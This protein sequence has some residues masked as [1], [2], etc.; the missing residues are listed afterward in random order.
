MGSASLARP[1]HALSV[2]SPTASLSSATGKSDHKRKR[3]DA[4]GAGSH[5]APSSTTV[6]SQPQQTGMGHHLL[7]QIHYAVEYLKE[8]DRA[9]SF[10]DIT[11]YL[12]LQNVS[13]QDRRAIQQTLQSHRSVD[14]DRHGLDGQGSFRFRPKHNVRSAEELRRYLQQRTTA[15]GIPVRELKDGW[16]G[17]IEAISMLENKGE[18]LV[19]RNK[20]DNQPKMVWLNDPSLSLAVDDEFQTMWHEVRLPAN[21]DELRGKLEQAGLKPTSAP[22]DGSMLKGQKREK[23][24]AVRRT[25]KLTNTHM[26]GILKDYSHKRKAG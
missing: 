10:T 16:S 5:G 9:L 24:R 18:V 3:G 25:G 17:A 2:P 7:T 8:K 22:K 6:Y 15:Q 13:E 4:F 21:P 23:K 14:Y 11:G 1:H 19:T 26:A 12:S 20:K